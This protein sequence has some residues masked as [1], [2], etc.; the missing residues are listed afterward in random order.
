[1]K[2]LLRTLLAINGGIVLLFGLMCLLTPWLGDISTALA[3]FASAP[4]M[5]GQMLGVALI[6]FA[7]LQFHAMADGALTG[8]VARLAGHMM[9]LMGLVLLVWELALGQPVVAGDGRLV[10][11]VMGIGL[12]LLGLIQAR[13]GG[14]VRARERRLARGAISAARAEQ[15]AVRERSADTVAADA[16]TDPYFGTPSAAVTRDATEAHF[17]SR[18]AVADPVLLTPLSSPAWSSHV[19]G[20]SEAGSDLPSRT[21]A[22]SAP[23]AATV[24]SSTVVAGEPREPHFS[25]TPAAGEGVEVADKHDALRPEQ[26]REQARRREVPPS[27]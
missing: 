21:S 3:G 25:A 12:L 26:E 14:M 5:I 6:A 15:G 11:T 20:G 7:A 23:A 27:F 19:T 9:W 18:T 16:S 13:L 8:A 17:S 10:A 4:A 24:V 1:M 2:P 22:S